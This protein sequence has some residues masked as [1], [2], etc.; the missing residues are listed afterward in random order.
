MVGV[1]S[2]DSTFYTET[3]AATF[4]HSYTVYNNLSQWN[5][6]IPPGIPPG[7]IDVKTHEKKIFKNVKNANDVT[8][9]KKRW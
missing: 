4:I 9:M 7:T 1:S 6:G 8:R 2:V 3:T 5:P